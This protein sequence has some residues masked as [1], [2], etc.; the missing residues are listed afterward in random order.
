MWQ[1]RRTRRSSCGGSS[2]A[3]DDWRRP[4]RRSTLPAEGRIRPPGR[5]GSQGGH[6]MA[7]TWVRALVGIVAFFVVL[8]I[9]LTVI[10]FDQTVAD[11]NLGLIAGR[12]TLILIFGLAV[13]GGFIAY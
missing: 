7:T 10:G 12:N 5:T 1:S 11:P 3:S 4:A 13:I 9:G 6:R 8:V 2:S